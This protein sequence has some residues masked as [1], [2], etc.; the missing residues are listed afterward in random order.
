[1]SSSNSRTPLAFPNDSRNRF[2]AGAARAVGSGQHNSLQQT[3]CGMGWSAKME[4]VY[5]PKKRMLGVV[6]LAIVILPLAAVLIVPRVIDSNKYHKQVQAQLEKRLGRKVSLNNLDLSLLPPS[7]RAENAVIAEDS[8]F[9]TGN[10]FATAEKLK[11]SVRFW[12]LLRGKVEIKS[13]ELDRP[14]IELVKDAQGVWNFS[15]L[16]Q[17]RKTSAPQPAASAQVE[18]DHLLITDGQVAITNQQLHRPRAVYDHIDLDVRDF[19]PDRQFSLKVS[20]LL[21]SV[22]KQA[23]QLEGTAGPIQPDALKTP[24]DGRLHLEQVPTAA[25]AAFLNTPALNAIEAVVS[26]EAKVNKSGGKLDSSGAIRLDDL[27]VHNV[28]VGYPVTMDYDITDDDAT[29]VIH[30]RRGDAKLGSTPVTVQGSINTRPT[31]A[32]VDVKFSTVNASIAET[33]R[34]VSAFGGA[35]FPETDATGQMSVSLQALGG[36]DHPVLNGKVSTLDLVIS[37]KELA[38]PVKVGAIDLTFTPE[39]VR[40]N[41]FHASCGPTTISASFALS[42]YATSASSISGSLLASN[43]KL[44]DILTMARAA[45]ISAANDVV[46]E[47]GV[48]LDVHAEG[49]MKDLAVTGKGKLQNATLTLPSL[50]Q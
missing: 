20:A 32:Q 3:F 4:W 10:P 30:I 40:S 46:G 14:R 5:M 29:G 43:A 45:G 6:A 33:A 31:P 21:P 19:A 2:R 25:A 41:E 12:P 16:G 50:G 34:L 1:M 27:H 11:V 38:L 26:G 7:F 24:F 37:R 42:Q 48:S 15:T 47:G 35:F 9:N 49:P 28:N 22:V 23:V 39:K 8:H 18:L 36:L 13:L 17:E 44:D